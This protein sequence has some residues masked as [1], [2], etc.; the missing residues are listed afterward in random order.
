MKS[1][2][3][4]RSFQ[5]KNKPNNY[6]RRVNLDFLCGLKEVMV[7]RTSQMLNTSNNYIRKV[8]LDFLC[9]LKEVMA[10]RTSQ[11]Y[12]HFIMTQLISF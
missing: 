3:P 7:R 12:K 8:N 5:S 2:L 10:R 4:C 9:G 11:M 6:I 1:R